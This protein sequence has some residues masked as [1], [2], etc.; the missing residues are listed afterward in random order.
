MVLTGHCLCGAVTYAAEGID[1][2][3]HGC[4]CGMCRR[5]GGTPAFAV[6]VDLVEFEGE[7]NVS[8]FESSA[9]AERG[10]CRRCG[11]H[12]FYRL[13][14]TGEYILWLGSF[15][16]LTPFS[17][18]MEIYIEEKPELYAL[19]GDRPRLTGEQVFELLKQ[20]GHEFFPPETP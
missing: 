19:A 6:R 18:G 5:W 17:L 7:D 10:F 4:H 12:L 11:T 2:E 9:W 3:V 15:D 1:T 16:D 8:R 14:E 13:K 20:E